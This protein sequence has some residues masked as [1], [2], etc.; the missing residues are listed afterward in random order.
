MK[1]RQEYM[2]DPRI[3]NDPL[4]SGALEPIRE[5]YAARLMLQDEMNGMTDVEKSDYINAQGRKFL[6]QYG[7]SDRLVNLS[8]EGKL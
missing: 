2:T 7:L 1:T 4:M 3:E 5:I 6:A 8:G